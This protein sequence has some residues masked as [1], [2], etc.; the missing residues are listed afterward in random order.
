MANEANTT[1]NKVVDPIGGANQSRLRA[2]NERLILSMI[3]RHGGIPKSELARRTGLTAQ[4]M[5]VIMR[6][7]ESDGL[8]LRGEPRRGRVGQPSVPMMLNPDGAFTIGLEI[9]RRR[10]DLVL[11]DFVGT[12]RSFMNVTYSH[13]Q[14]DKTLDFVRGGLNELIAVLTPEQEKRITGLG[15]AMPFELW[16]WRENV[17][18]PIGEM[19]A[20][21]NINMKSELEKL[22]PYPV[23]IQN[24]ATA[25]CGAE[26]VFGRGSEIEDFV[27]FFI[28]SFIGGG[29]VL[30]HNVFPG[31]SGNAGALGSMPV[32]GSDGKPVQLIEKASI[33]V[34]ENMLREKGLDPSP[35]WLSPDS[36]DGFGEC[37]E[38]WIANISKHLA[39]AIVSSSSVID[40][41]AAII[42][43]AFPMDVRTRIVDTTAAAIKDFDTQG[44]NVPQVLSGKVGNNARVI[45][46]ASLPL[47]LHY[48]LDQNILFK[49]T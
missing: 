38:E 31:R 43:G 7:L 3:R 37:L 39:M 16:S 41:G 33:Y 13:P 48:L 44:I 6:S 11:M 49:E 34:L 15:V 12:Q 35:L 8:L 19:E 5:S 47:F 36:W 27:Y 40:F 21:R 10:A 1:K 28:G 32:V 4:S 26:L 17:E 25:A 2:Y 18:A 24:D 9:G 42:D 23:Q 29:I 22:C 20:W 46:A 45:G 30:N 14:P